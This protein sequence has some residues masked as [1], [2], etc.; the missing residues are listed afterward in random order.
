MANYLAGFL[1]PGGWLG[2]AG[3]G[4]MQEIEGSVPDHLRAWWEPSLCCLHTAAWWRRHW[5]RTGI[6]DVDVADTLP[7]GWRLWRDWQTVVAPDNAA[8]IEALEADRGSY[9][10]YTR[11]IG[12]RRT[13]ARLDE[14]I[15][16]I[17]GSYTKQPLLRRSD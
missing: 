16:S 14:P 10:G 2:V 6:L 11:L 7:D 12:R 13:D 5:E 9:L 4:L 8:E 3:L 17:P 15:V 1:K